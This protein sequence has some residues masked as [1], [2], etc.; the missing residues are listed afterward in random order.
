LGVECAIL[1][2]IVLYG[3]NIVSFVKDIQFKTNVLWEDYQIRLSQLRSGAG[4]LHRR[5]TDA[6]E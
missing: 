4:V 5:S 1:A 2:A 3:W 6:D